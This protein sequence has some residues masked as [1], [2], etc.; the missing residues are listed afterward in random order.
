MD[1]KPAYSWTDRNNLVHMARSYYNPSSYINNMLWIPLCFYLKR[2]DG[3]VKLQTLVLI[4]NSNVINRLKIP[5]L[6]TEHPK[7]NYWNEQW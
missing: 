5:I 7:N 4:N 3:G 1:S 2:R 6:E